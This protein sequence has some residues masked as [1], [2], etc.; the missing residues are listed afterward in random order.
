MTYTLTFVWCNS[1]TEHCDVAP[2][3]VEMM[4]GAAPPAWD[5]MSL[6]P[7]VR[8]GACPPNH[9]WRNGG[10]YEFDWRDVTAGHKQGGIEK[11]LGLTMHECSLTV[12][13]AF[14]HSGK[15]YKFVYFAAAE[16]LPSLLFDLDADPGD[17]FGHWPAF[18]NILVRGSQSLTRCHRAAR[19]LDRQGNRGTSLPPLR[20]ERS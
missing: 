6:L 20:M 7:F 4:H 13:H 10:H 18:D 9:R 3:L 1:V 15:R 16:R 8:E 5:G 19:C 11:A 14:K 12:L 17:S 2:T